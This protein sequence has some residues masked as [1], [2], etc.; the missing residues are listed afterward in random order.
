VFRKTHS[1]VF[2]NFLIEQELLTLGSHQRGIERIDD[3]M[4]ATIAKKPHI[5][6]RRQQLNY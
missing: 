2:G 5:G 6:R 4:K 1:Q 3:D